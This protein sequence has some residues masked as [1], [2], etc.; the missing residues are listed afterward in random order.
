[1]RII[2]VSDTHIS[3]L[4]GRASENFTFLTDYINE[5]LRPDL[6]INTGDVV[7]LNPDNAD[8]RRTARDLHN[9]IKVPLRVLPGNHDVGESS[10]DP[11]M[12]IGVKSERIAGFV[13]TWGPDRFLELGRPELGAGDWAFI[14]L[15]SE[16]MS[17]GLAEEAE[18][19]DWLDQVAASVQG[20]SVAVF[21][22]KP[23]WWPGEDK[24]VTVPR[25]DRDRLLRTFGG[26]RLRLVANGHVH[27][28]GAGAEGDVNTVWAPS[29]A[30]ASPPLPE[31][32]L[33]ASP[34]GVVEY[35]IE[36]DVFNAR[37]CPVPGVQGSD[38]I[39]SVPEVSAALA[40]LE[41][42]PAG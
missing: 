30:F 21:L 9:R 42:A 29:L 36:G 2:Q 22:H 33:P 37:F 34:S 26:A 40:E 7:V 20:M 1:V 6:V 39:L 28:F 27:R 16:R 14:G 19:W 41:S 17:S 18:Q 5:V 23:L 12:G 32:A 13:D 3:H 38:D 4:G 31:Y 25:T 24:G 35:N 15:N 11:W 10:D 8:D